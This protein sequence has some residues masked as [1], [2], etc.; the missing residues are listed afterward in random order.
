[1]EKELGGELKLEEAAKQEKTQPKTQTQSNSVEAEEK[2]EDET[3]DEAD[4]CS[5]SS[6]SSISCVSSLC[7]TSQHGKG[8]AITV[9]DMGCIFA[10]GDEP[11]KPADIDN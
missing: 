5:T 9:D 11:L 1:M 10:A 7:T 8:E 4:K 2:T 3:E 6:V